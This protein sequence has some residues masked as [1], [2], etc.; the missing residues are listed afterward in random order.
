MIN[1]NK[2]VNMIVFQPA[3]AKNHIEEIRNGLSRASAARIIIRAPGCLDNA[4]V[5]EALLEKLNSST[6]TSV[7]YYQPDAAPYG[8]RFVGGMSN[9]EKDIVTRRHPDIA[10]WLHLA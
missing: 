1:E 6:W 7:L 8:T 2:L 9:D 10:G 5:R 4:E 3:I